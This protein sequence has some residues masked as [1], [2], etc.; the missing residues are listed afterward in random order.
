MLNQS[1]Y[2]FISCGLLSLVESQYEQNISWRVDFGWLPAQKE[3]QMGNIMGW[4]NDN[5]IKKKA[6]ATCRRE[7]K[8][9]EI[10]SPFHASGQM[11][12]EF[13]GSGLLVHMA[14]P[15]EGKHHNP[16]YPSLLLPT[17]PFMT[18]CEAYS[19][20]YLLSQFRSGAPAVSLQTSCLSAACWP[21]EWW[22]GETALMLCE[23][24]SA[25]AKT[26]VSYQHPW[27]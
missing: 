3:N 26:S 23:L 27:S 21:S 4:D 9:E 7:E 6:K 22:V 5:L 15:S 18:G 17:L 25:I 24:C 12:S 11:S 20:E 10:Y 16:K 8:K 2:Y 19:V 1:T 13:L 14:I